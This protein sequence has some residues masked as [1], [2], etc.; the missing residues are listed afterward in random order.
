MS[1]YL[2]FIPPQHSQRP[3]F[4]STVD[5]SCSPLEA[6]ADAAD[7]L[8][9]AFDLDTA[10]GRQ[11]DAVGERINLAR[12]LTT[13][14]ADLYF[15]TD[16][17]L[18]GADQGI[19]YNPGYGEEYGVTVLDDDTYRTLLRAKILANRWDGTLPQA[20]LI[21]QAIFAEYPDTLVMVLDESTNGSPTT[22]FSTDDPEAGADQGQSYNPGDPPVNVGNVSTG[23][24]V[25]V[26]GRLPPLALLFL[27]E[28]ELIPV[29]SMGRPV[30]YA[31]TSLDGAPIFGCDADN[32]Y[33][34]GADHGAVGVSAEQILDAPAGQVYAQG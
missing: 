30:N 11:L 29:R 23:F 6:V 8:I 10:V 20:R 7:G 32:E 18:R 27:L 15:S 13:P 31:F 16:D 24:A 22:Y 34:G 5:L 12:T 14:I 33:I 25:C 26:A 28:Q 2:D 3:R 19:S 9:L 21:V 17:P 1:R 4:V